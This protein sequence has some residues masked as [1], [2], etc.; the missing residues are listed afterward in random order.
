MPPPSAPAPRPRNRWLYVHREK[1][2]HAS[3]LAIRYTYHPH[4]NISWLRSFLSSDSS[5]RGAR[6]AHSDGRQ[7][8]SFNRQSEQ[9]DSL[10]CE[11]CLTANVRNE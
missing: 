1:L 8:D 7:P 9:P 5:S 2:G 11:Q 6:F 4:G 3:I 10:G